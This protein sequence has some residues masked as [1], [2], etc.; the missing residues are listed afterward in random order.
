MEN[1]ELTM[2]PVSAIYPHPDNPRKDVGDVTELADSIKK[3]G[4]LQNLTVMPGHWLTMDEM[5]AVVEAY[6]EDPTDE[7][8]ELIETKWSDEGYTTLI[9]H[10]RT[11]AAKLA[12]ISEAPCRIVYGLTKNEQISM[13]LEEN[14][15][16]NDLT[17]YEQAE[18][19]QLMLYPR[20]MT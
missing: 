11:A 2:L 9:G 15:Q 6:T 19:F 18:S 20:R 16:R 12:G 10:R 1:E 8:K 13:M 4:I 14:M 5:A 7:L 17:I 3:R